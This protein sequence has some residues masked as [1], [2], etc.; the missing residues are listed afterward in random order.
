MKCCW[1]VLPVPRL[2]FELI[3]VMKLPRGVTE[4]KG[5]IVMT[6]LVTPIAKNNMN[7]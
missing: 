6:G 2:L 5:L 4:A 1:Q 3:L 7:P